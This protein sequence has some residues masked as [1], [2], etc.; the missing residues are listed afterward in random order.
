MTHL[1]DRVAQI[2]FDFAG[3]GASINCNKTADAIMAAVELS[4]AQT[5]I[6]DLEA[7]KLETARRFSQLIATQTHEEYDHE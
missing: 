1:R 3:G 2:I 5:K 4:A 6:A 7:D